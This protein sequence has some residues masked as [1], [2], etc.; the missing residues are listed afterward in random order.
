MKNKNVQKSKGL[1]YFLYFIGFFGALGFHRFYIGKIGT[2]LIWMVTGGA[3]GIGSVYDLFT[4]SS[5]VD[6]KNVMS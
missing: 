4:L 2:G 1:A 3:A 5:Q 6:E